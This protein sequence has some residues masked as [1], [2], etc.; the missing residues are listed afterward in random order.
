MVGP[1]AINS[2]S[3]VGDIFLYTPIIIGSTAVP[4]FLSAPS[5]FKKTNA[6]PLR[7]SRKFFPYCSE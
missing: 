3:F 1:I 5:M 2:L 7:E 4:I 6:K